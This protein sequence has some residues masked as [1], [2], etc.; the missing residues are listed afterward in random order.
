MW[1][2]S[3]RDIITPILAYTIA[4][5]EWKAILSSGASN[6]ITDKGVVMAAGELKYGKE[7]F[8]ICELQ[9][10][11]RMETNPAAHLFADKLLKNK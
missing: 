4:A 7:V 9:L 1:Y 8:R 6:W 5:P 3:K 11:D 2:N 10:L